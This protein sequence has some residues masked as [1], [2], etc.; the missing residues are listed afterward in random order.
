M[1]KEERRGWKTMRGEATKDV[2]EIKGCCRTWM[3][4]GQLK[5]TWGLSG[6][7]VCNISES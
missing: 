3:S 7:G 1:R 6:K 5:T 2:E 4:K